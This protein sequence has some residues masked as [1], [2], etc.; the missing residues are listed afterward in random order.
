M[1][2]PA[3]S[4]RKEGGDGSNDS[5][6]AAA[7]SVDR[8]HSKIP[9]T[10]EE[11]KQILPL[12]SPP[13]DKEA[14][15]YYTGLPS[16]PRLIGRASAGIVRW[17]SYQEQ[18]ARQLH[19][20]WK[21]PAQKVLGAVGEHKIL[22]CWSDVRPA[23]LTAIRHLPWSSVDVCRIGF[24]DDSH[25]ERPV[26]I[27]IGVDGNPDEPSDLPWQD[28]AGAIRSCRQILD[29]AGLVDVD[30]QLRVSRV[31]SLASPQLL[32]PPP[33]IYARWHHVA[34]RFT[35]SLGL[36]LSPRDRPT[37]EGSLGVFLS[38]E[39]T[40]S[41][42]AGGG[43][44]WAVTCRHVGLPS[45]GPHD[46]AYYRLQDGKKRQ[47]GHNVQSK[48]EQWIEHLSEDK[49]RRADSTVAADVAGL[50]EAVK[51]FG[52]EDARQIGHVLLSP[53]IGLRQTAVNWTRDWCL[54]DLDQS[55]F[56]GGERPV[57]VVDLRTDSLP[58][59]VNRLLNPHLRNEHK[60][61][62]PQNGL[63]RISGVIP[64]AEIRRPTM[65]D[66][67]GENCLLVGK[68]GAVSGLTWGSPLEL[69][70]TVRNCLP[71]GST[72]ISNE[73]A[74]HGSLQKKTVPFS[75]GG[76]SGAAVFDTRGRLGGFVTR[77]TSPDL[78]LTVDITYATPAELVLADI[79]EE[80]GKKVVL[81]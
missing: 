31:V 63:L 79:E 18:Y 8:G 42:T 69:E 10:I 55:K 36:S 80:L 5:G 61:E 15:L 81:L 64:L 34:Q 14:R 38:T 35:T 40:A 76:D 22:A 23:I 13:C 4:P 47:V 70:S 48:V 66:K 27:W 45:D 2:S 21:T 54:L 30:C 62:F 16:R 11:E 52:S 1:S 46:N 29:N 67:D 56:P 37:P 32:K 72:F 24:A 33:R 60:F 78:G 57:N 43:P 28:V 20:A 65:Y 25:L 17:E 49:K 75:A 7:S 12:L 71:N 26:V 50:Y 9:T 73:W 58:S 6:T 3:K 59:E 44:L 77:G 19:Q 53:P 39:S 41:T 51:N 68:R 74:I